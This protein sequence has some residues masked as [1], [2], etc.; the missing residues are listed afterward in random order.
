MG[1][2]ITFSPML[3]ILQVMKGRKTQLFTY[4]MCLLPTPGDFHIAQKQNPPLFP[5]LIHL[6]FLPTPKP[7]PNTEKVIK[8][9]FISNFAVAKHL[10]LQKRCEVLTPREAFSQFL[11]SFPNM[12][13]IHEN[14]FMYQSRYFL[15]GI[16]CKNINGFTP[17]KKIINKR[18]PIYVSTNKIRT[19]QINLCHTCYQVV[20]FI[21]VL[22]SIS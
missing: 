18:N 2:A 14:Q 17:H 12:E 15:G 22:V 8:L 6:Y 10:P 13:R 7:N 9:I 3:Q 1:Y 16:C 21:F 11:Y 19:N 5:S 20:V 4:T